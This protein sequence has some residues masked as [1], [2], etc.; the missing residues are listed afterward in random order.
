MCEREGLALPF[1]P[2]VGCD[3]GFAKWQKEA[4]AS[5]VS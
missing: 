5:F 1:L 3:L 2:G 4:R